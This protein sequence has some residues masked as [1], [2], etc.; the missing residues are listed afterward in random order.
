MEGGQPLRPVA[1][2]DTRRRTWP[3]A[4]RIVRRADYAACYETGRRF[5]TEHFIVFV[6]YG[7][8]DSPA[9]ARLGSAVS[10]KV[11]KAVLRNRIKRLLREFFRH[12]VRR[13]PGGTDIVVVAKKQAGEAALRQSDVDRQLGAI[14]RRLAKNAPE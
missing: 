4:C 14:L 5:H 6:R 13:I 2:G 3:R 11:G 7:R 8:G 9:P 10:R 12:H 1:G